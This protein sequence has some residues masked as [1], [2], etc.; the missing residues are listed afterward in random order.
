MV[1]FS[2]FYILFGIPLRRQGLTAFNPELW[3][4]LLVAIFPDPTNIIAALPL[5][6][7]LLA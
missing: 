5:I 4:A 3:P 6:A 7:V 2:S 1:L